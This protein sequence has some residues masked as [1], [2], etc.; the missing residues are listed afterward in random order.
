[1]AYGRD[2]SGQRD[3]GERPF[4]DDRGAADARVAAA[5]AAYQ[6]G[7]CSEQAA[8]AALAGARLLVPVVAVLAGAAP[9]A[10]AVPRHPGT[11]A[12]KGA[13]EGETADKG[14]EMM[15]PTLIGRDGRPALPAFTCLDALARWRADARPVPAQA[16][17]VWRAAVDGG[18]AVVIDVAGPVPVAVE[19]TRLAALAAGRPPPPPHEDPDVRAEIEAAL[20]GESHI[21]GFVLGPGTPGGAEL[22][23]GLR[24]APGAA[25]PALHRAATAIAA[26]LGIRLRRGIQI[27]VG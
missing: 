2:V 4:R 3:H 17:R 21:A 7:R 10:A 16:G 22:A 19:G 13:G 24:P 18:C 12:D 9:R 20:A 14:S 1:V 25:G 5:L 8:L 15:L 27:G 11:G 26:R 6:A 23:I